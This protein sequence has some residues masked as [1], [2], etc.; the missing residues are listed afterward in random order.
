MFHFFILDYSEGELHKRLKTCHAYLAENLDLTE[1]L[2]HLL[3]EGVVTTSDAEAI[4]AKTGAF[5]QNCSLLD[6]LQSKSLTQIERFIACLT[7]TNQAHL[8]K[9]IDPNGNEQICQY[10]YYLLLSPEFILIKST[11][12]IFML[13]SLL[14]TKQPEFVQTIHP[15]SAVYIHVL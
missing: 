12:Q 13:Y 1:L 8:V 5:K 11:R 4:K 15:N 6:L 2:H 10:I 3:S 7:A 9:K 14:T